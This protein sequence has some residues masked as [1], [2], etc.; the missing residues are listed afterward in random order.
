M[1]EH[2]PDNEKTRNLPQPDDW[3]AGRFKIIRVIGKGGF[4]TVYEAH[5]ESMGDRLVALKILAPKRQ[6]EHNAVERFRQEALLASRLH[7]PNTITL[8]DFG[9]TPGGLFSIASE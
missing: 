6:A 8:L 9:A 1:S 4:G 3:I 2:P 5:Q 7:H